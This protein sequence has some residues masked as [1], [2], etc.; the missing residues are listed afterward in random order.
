MKAS[1]IEHSPKW[2]Q[3]GIDGTSGTHS[4]APLEED[5][6]K[7]QAIAADDKN[8]GPYQLR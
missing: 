1:S 7:T 8:I 2:L 3:A 6:D 4:G 5:V